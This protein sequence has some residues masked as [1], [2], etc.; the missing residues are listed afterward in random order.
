MPQWFSF[1]RSQEGATASVSVNVSINAA[2]VVPSRPTAFLLVRRI[3]D[4]TD[5]EPERELEERLSQRLAAIEV[6]VVATL[7]MSGS[8]TLVAYGRD[9]DQPAIDAVLNESGVRFATNRQEDA[10]WAIY[11]TLLPSEA[12]ITPPQ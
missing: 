9:D 8:R 10:Q 7:T 11:R 4:G 6:L 5:P 1:V 2:E 12:E 3:D